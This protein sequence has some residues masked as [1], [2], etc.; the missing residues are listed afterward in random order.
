MF[1]FQPSKGSFK[2][3]LTIKIKT[4]I[5]SL[6]LAPLQMKIV[7]QCSNAFLFKSITPLSFQW[8][9]FFF[10]ALNFGEKDKIAEEKGS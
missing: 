10:Y 1:C 7:L 6:L 5:N 9:Y 3:K 4:K 8:K 2:G